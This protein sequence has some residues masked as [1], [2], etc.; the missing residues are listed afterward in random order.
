MKGAR[1]CA[2]YASTS[3]NVML[4]GQLEWNGGDALGYDC[5]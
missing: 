5:T 4:E 3:S 1:R 2:L